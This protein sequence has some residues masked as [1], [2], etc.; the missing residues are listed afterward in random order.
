MTTGEQVSVPANPVEPA[1]KLP[2]IR[3]V[4][5]QPEPTDPETAASWRQARDNFA[6][7]VAVFG[8]ALTGQFYFSYV[9]AD[10]LDG[11]GFFLASTALFLFLVYRLEGSRTAGPAVLR[12]LR[13]GQDLLRQNMMRTVL[14]AMGVALAY[15]EIRLLLQKLDTQPYWDVL[16][17]WIASWATYAAAFVRLPRR[18]WRAVWLTYRTE[19]IVVACLTGLAAAFRLVELGQVPNIISGDEGIIGNLAVAALNGNMRNMMATVYGQSTFYLFIIAGF[20]RLLGVSATSLRLAAAISG[21]LT[22]PALYVLA[23]RFFNARVALVAASLLTVSHFHLHFSRIIVAAGIQDALFAT[24]TF[25]FFYTGLQERSV[26][27]LT[28]SGLISGFAMYM[29]MGARLVILLLPVYVLFL[30]IF[31]RQLVRDNLGNLLAALGALIIIAA[32]LLLWAVQHPDEFNARANQVGIFQSG[33]LVAEAHD[34]GLSQWRILLDQLEKA[35]LTVNYYPA[36]AFY[37]SDL[38]MLDFVSGALFVLGLAYSLFF[39]ADPRYLLLNGWFWSG[40]VVGGA[41]VVL[42]DTSHYRILLIFPVVCLFVGLAWDRLMA[43]GSRILAG[44]HPAAQAAPTM[45]LIGAFSFINLKAYFVDYAPTCRYEDVNTRM[46]SEIGSTIGQLGP[47]Y[48]PYLLTAPRLL[49]GTYESLDFFSHRAHVIEIKDPLTAPPTNIDPHQHAVFFFIPE[50]QAELAYVQAQLPGG[51][52][53]QVLDCK[54]LLMTVY[55][56]P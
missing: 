20:M 33:W 31:D 39:L 17:L 45:L 19:I 37:Y 54:N 8:L 22:V 6:L 28:L 55:V 56:V 41:L 48:T 44:L 38:P 2:A 15:T 43:F 16:L 10:L 30:L 52:V 24:L 3:P 42:P 7:V 12:L 13:R 1:T 4:P 40:I 35:F 27:R 51:H 53:D 36:Y 25:Y 46:A 11:I 14:V 47:G 26:G 29:Y 21:V 32:P 23:R 5:A 50:R 34:T 18:D 9:H 49:Y